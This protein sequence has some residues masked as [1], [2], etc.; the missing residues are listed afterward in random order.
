MMTFWFI[1]SG[2]TIV[3]LGLLVWPLLKGPAAVTAGEQEKK[4]SV[5]RQQFAELK[6]DHRNGVLTDEQYQVA[7]RELERRVLEETG[8]EQGPSTGTAH[9]VSGRAVALAL[10]I[11][12]PTV[13]GLLYVKLGSPSAITHSTIQEGSE[14]DLQS[15]RGLEALAERLKAKLEQNPTDGVGWALLAR[16]YVELGRHPEAVP[17]YEKA[18]QLRPNDAQLLADYAD[19]LGVLQD[20]KLEGKPEALIRQALKADPRNI[21]AL[22]LA[23][24]V[25]Y[26]HKDYAR[27]ASYWEEAR[28]NLPPDID[29]GVIQELID[30]IAEAKELGGVRQA[31]EKP[32]PVKPAGEAKPS[33]AISGQVTLAPGLAT[34]GSPTDT[35]FVFARA[36]E[37]PPMPVAIVRGAKK[38][39]PFT[40]Q[41]DDSNSPMP[42]R[43]LSEAGSV[44]IVARLSQSGEAAPKRGDLQ[45][46][47]QPVKPGVKGVRV[48][49]DREIP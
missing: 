29:Q 19:A 7:R 9:H 26:N 25:A 41:L 2:L 24:T 21:K 45:G 47:S 4:L 14:A 12:L 34:K 35:L 48:T 3:I 17:I 18:I 40:F 8:T 10:A 20:R 6:Q 15:M 27:A 37:G 22:M 42:A 1:A 36:V 44:V 49:I 16:A 32:V 31:T 43:K 23:G 46:M 30:G 11:V 13:S 33:L 38:D 5:Y 39:L 28:A